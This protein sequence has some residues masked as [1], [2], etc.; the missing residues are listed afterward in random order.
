MC[1]LLHI[2]LIYICCSTWLGHIWTEQTQLSCSCC[3]EGSKIKSEPFTGISQGCNDRLISRSK[4]N[5]NNWLVVSVILWPKMSNICLFQLLK[6][7]DFVVCMIV[8]RSLGFGPLVGKMK[9]FED[10][11]LWQKVLSPFGHFRNEMVN[12]LMHFQCNIS[13]IWLLGMVH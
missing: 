10:F 6:C 4:E 8:R 7:K 11:G 3:W 9:Q 5:C 12:S 13:I 2:C 1:R